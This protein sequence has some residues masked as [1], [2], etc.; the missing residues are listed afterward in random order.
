[1]TGKSSCCL[2]RAEVDE[3]AVDLVEHLGGPRVGAV[4]LVQAD[5]RLEARFERLS[6][7]EARLRQRALRGVDQEQDAVDHGERALD[8]A[9]EV[10]VARA[11]RRC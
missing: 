7:D 5:D 8:L 11:C 6:E 4:D 2:A 9:A 1:M 3:E 10:G